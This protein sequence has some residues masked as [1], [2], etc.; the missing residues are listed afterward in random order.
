MCVIDV[1]FCYYC[2]FLRFF[3]LKINIIVLLFKKKFNFNYI[4]KFETPQKK[5][6][7]ITDNSFIHSNFSWWYYEY[8][9]TFTKAFIIKEDKVVSSI[10][11]TTITLILL[12]WYLLHFYYF[13]KENDLLSRI[14]SALRN[15]LSNMKQQYKPVKQTNSK[16]KKLKKLKNPK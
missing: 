8:S 2:I 11:L 1:F 9:S 10:F 16:N 14:I 3:F 15:M 13:D 5:M 4:I 7:Y 6:N 12:I